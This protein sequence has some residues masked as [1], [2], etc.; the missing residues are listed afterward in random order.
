MRHVTLRYAVCVLLA[1]SL[2]ALSVPTLALAAPNTREGCKNQWLFNGIWRV[3]VT[4]V[5]PFMNGSQQAGWQVT[6]TWRNGTARELAPGESV[7]DNEILEL[8]NGSVAAKDSTSGSLSLGNVG[9]N[10]FPPAGEYT[11]K[12]VFLTNGPTDPNNK[13][14][15]LSIVFNGAL[16][17]KLNKPQFT[18]SQY[19]F[20][21]D[22]NCV[23]TGARAQAQGGS[24]QVDARE[25]CLNQWMSNG[26]WRMRVTA[27]TPRYLDP[28]NPST[29]QTGWLIAQ[30]WQNISRVRLFPGGLTDM[31]HTGGPVYGSNVSDEYLTTQGGNSVSSANTVGDMGPFPGHVFDRGATWSFQQTMYPNAFNASDKPSRVLV[32]FDAKTQN[33]LPAPHPH[34]SKPA[35]FRIDLACSK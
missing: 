23:A 24:T 6:E 5:E 10:P 20:H 18:T 25:G 11:Y 33:T 34:Y 28:N 3:E 31:G 27:V 12:Q 30:D 13:P 16:L 32:T 26:V 19:N 15:G 21:Y 22:L 1:L 35:N 4:N 2:L 29:N 9:N 17:A 14:K 7:L 8:D